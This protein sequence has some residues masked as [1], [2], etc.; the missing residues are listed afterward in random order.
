MHFIHTLISTQMSSEDNYITGETN[1]IMCDTNVD[2]CIPS[3]N[4]L[5]ASGNHCARDG[6]AES[7][8]Q[9]PPK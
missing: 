8:D 3:A 2:V 9:P 5:R 1:A 7:G 4:V 6:Y